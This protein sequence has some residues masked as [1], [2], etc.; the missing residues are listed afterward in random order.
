[1]SQNWNMPTFRR[2]KVQK[3]LD[4]RPKV[5]YVTAFSNNSRGDGDIMKNEQIESE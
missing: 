1:M 2:I 3:V 4:E 5:K